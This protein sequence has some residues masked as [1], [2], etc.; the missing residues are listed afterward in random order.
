VRGDA[1]QDATLAARLEDE[2]QVAVLEIPDAAMHETRRPARG[3]AREV[4]AFDER[5]IEATARGITGDARARNA[6][7]DDQHVE[8][9][10]A[11]A[12]D[13]FGAGGGRNGRQG[14]G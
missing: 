9:A 6:P 8:A 7:A 4:A 3:A 12:L 14:L 11:E 1:Q 10:L 13:L 5:D 2:V